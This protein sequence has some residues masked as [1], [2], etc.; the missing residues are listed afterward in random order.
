MP[1]YHLAAQAAVP[2]F[3]AW[4]SSAGEPDARNLDRARFQLDAPVPAGRG[5]FEM[6]SFM[7]NELAAL[8]HT[9]FEGWEA[10]A[11]YSPGEPADDREIFAET[12]SRR[13][14]RYVT[15]LYLAALLYFTNKFGDADLEAARQ[16]LFAWA[17]TPRV[18]FLRVQFRTIDK[19]AQGSEALSAFG[20]LRN[21]ATGRAIHELS[22]SS[23]QYKDGHENALSA[24]LKKLGAR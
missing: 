2:L 19:L 18:G 15:E 21:A 10:F 11:S 16:R 3:G 12:P 6:V 24:V 17:F 9:A 7:L 4:A 22:S 23:K 14:Y 5:F 1:A 13:R 8:R 20:L